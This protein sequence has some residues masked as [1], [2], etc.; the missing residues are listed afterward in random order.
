MPGRED[1]SPWLASVYV[2]PPYRRRGIGAA[3]VRRVVQEASNQRIPVVYLYT[4]SKEN[5]NF[6]TKLGWSVCERVEFLGKLRVIME[7]R[8]AI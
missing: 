4:T 1:L 5:E 3:L 6:Y 7:I 8:T 2:A